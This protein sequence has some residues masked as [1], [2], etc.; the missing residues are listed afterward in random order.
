MICRNGGELN[1]ENKWYKFLDTLPEVEANNGDFGY[2]MMRV[3]L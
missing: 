2:Y 1:M 3:Q